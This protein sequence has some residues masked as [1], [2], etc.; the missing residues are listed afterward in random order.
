MLFSPPF[1]LATPEDAVVRVIGPDLTCSGTLVE[2]DLVLT[3]HH[4]LV[5]RAP[6]GAMT[7]ETLDP[8]DLQ[9]ELGGDY[10]AW[11]TVRV[12]AI[13]TPPCGATGGAGD[14]AVLVLERK[15]VGMSTMTPRL[16]AP[17]RMGEPLDPIGFGRCALSDDGVHRHARPGGPIVGTASETFVLRAS[18]CPGDSGGPVVARGTHEIV[19]VV[20][21][22]A[23]D[24]DPLTVGPT[25]GA[26]LDVYRAVFSTARLVADGV[27]PSE[28][29]PL[30][31]A[32]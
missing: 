4:C 26:R 3:A 31:C 23:M 21:Q 6:S 2:D 15:L 22:S 10:L 20:S 11:G 27:D 9:I 17:P 29:P 30:S 32:P 8:G 5:K 28:I 24:G 7:R 18:I 13:V 16:D 12:R 1:A 25:I 19:G 14:V